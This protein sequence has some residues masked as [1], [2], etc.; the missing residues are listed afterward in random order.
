[1]N[2]QIQSINENWR[3]AYRQHWLHCRHLESQRATFTSIIAASIAAVLGFVSRDG[4][5]GPEPLYFLIALT[6][7]G[8]LLTA[9]WT[10]AFEHH[11][12]KINIIASYLGLPPDDADVP[13]ENIWRFIRA[14][15]LFH[16]FYIVLLG[17]LLWFLVKT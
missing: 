12:Q 1:M 9:R 15:Y 6:I 4:V 11:R 16:L 7:V 14:R 13:A 2:P 10:N 17:L 5:I 8:G 3:E